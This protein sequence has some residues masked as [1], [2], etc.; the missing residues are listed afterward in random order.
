MKTELSNDTVCI[1]GGLHPVHRVVLSTMLLY[2][3]AKWQSFKKKQK[4]SAL[5]IECSLIYILSVSYFL[6]LPIKAIRNTKIP[7]NAANSEYRKSVGITVK[8][9]VK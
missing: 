9:P 1:H 8:Y 2:I 5:S 7:T 3:T 6:W 4:N